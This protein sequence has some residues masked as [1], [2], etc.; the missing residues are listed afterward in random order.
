MGGPANKAPV[1]SEPDQPSVRSFKQLA[2]LAMEEVSEDD[3]IPDIGSDGSEHSREDGWE[4]P[5]PQPR[6]SF[7][8]L[9]APSPVPSPVVSPDQSPAV[10]QH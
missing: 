5:V 9:P 1:V 6:A 10:P 4:P 2:Y 3:L 7:P 8:P